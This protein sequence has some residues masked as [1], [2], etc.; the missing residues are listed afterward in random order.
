MGSEMCIR[1]RNQGEG[2]RDQQNQ[3]G[4]NRLDGEPNEAGGLGG[5]TNPFNR[6]N[7]APITGDDFREWSDRLRDVEEMIA[8]PD[9]RADAAR[10]RDRAKAIRKDLKRHSPEP[11]WN[12]I[13]L[14][15][16]QPLAELRSRVT[17][18]IL[19]R[20]P[21][22]ELVPLNREPVPTRYENAVR[23]YYKTLGTGQ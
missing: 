10:I 22:N 9:L 20:D 21:K 1:D 6:G 19:R 11:D 18:E 8:D 3:R 17:Q 5:A 13:K 14:E 4:G 7:F 16:A 2:N 15:L 23:E 12:K